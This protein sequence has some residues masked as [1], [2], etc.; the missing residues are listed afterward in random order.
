[1][2]H[3]IKVLEINRTTCENVRMKEC[4]SHSMKEVRMKEINKAFTEKPKLIGTTRTK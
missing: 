1:M 2:V 3:E 4:K